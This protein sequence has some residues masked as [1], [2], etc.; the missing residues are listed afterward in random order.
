MLNWLFGKNLYKHLSETRRVRVK[1]INFRI[2][3]LNAINYIDGSKALRQSYDTYK[4]KGA[5]VSTIQD[6]KKV[7]EHFAHVLVGG[8][9][10]PVLSHANDG[11]GIHVDALFVDWDM[12]VGL[13]TEIMTFTYGKKKVKQLAS[14]ETR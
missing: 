1:G 9:V 10:S 12:V 8:V 11:S 3:R 4:T 13:Y 5:N 7:T 6:D 2:R 14:L